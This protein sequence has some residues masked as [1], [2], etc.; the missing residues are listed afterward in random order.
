MNRKIYIK[1]KKAIISLIF[2]FIFLTGLN[3]VDLTNYYLPKPDSNYSYYIVSE[4]DTL[5]TIA[6][7]YGFKID[8]RD[9]INLIK[10]VNQI[11]DNIK[12]GSVLKIPGEVKSK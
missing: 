2:I 4:K 1:K 6:D 3:I 12:P 9:Y 5:W 11:G 7:E 8:K 10:E